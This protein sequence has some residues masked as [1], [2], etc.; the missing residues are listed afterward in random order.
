MSLAPG[1]RLGPYEVLAPLGAGGMGEVYRARDTRLE[2]TVAIKVLPEHLSRSEEVRQ[3]FEREAKTISALS[4]PH[5]CALYD[6]GREGETEYLVM[7]YLEGETLSDRL[8]KGPLPT[9][10]LLRWG[11]EIA[12]ALD[13]AH[14]Q[15]IV[16][17]DL[18]PGNV[19][20]TKSGVKLLDFGLAKTFE[21]SLD[22]TGRGRAAAG[23]DPTAADGITALPTVM[24]SPNLTQAGTILGTFQYMAPEQLEGR[25]ADARSDIFAFGAVLYE[26]ATG[27]KAFEGKSQASLIASILTSDPAPIST[28][29]PLTPPALER[30]VRTCLA[31][32]PEDRWQSAH[33]IA[34]QLSWIAQG[35]SV[36]GVAAP[37]VASRRRQDRLAWVTLGVL[38]GALTAAAVGWALW[39]SRASG[40]GLVTRAVIP[41]P[42][43]ETFV[44]DNYSTLAISPDGRRVAYVARRDNKRQ[45]VQRS[46]DAAEGTSIAGTDG[47]YS[48]FFSPD[49]QWLGFSADG[50]L[51]KVALAGGTPVT[52]CECGSRQLLGAS[53]GADDTIVFP[54]K[55]GGPILRVPSSGGMPSAV[56][57]ISGKGSDRGHIFP[58]LLPGGKAVLFSVFSGGSLDDYTVDVQSLV[59]GERKTLVKGGTFGRYA[60]SGHVLYIRGATLFAVPFDPAR[61]QVTGSAFPVAQG[62]YEN[63]NGGAGYAVSGSGTL[64]YSGGGVQLPGRSLLWVDRQ[65]HATPASGIKRPFNDIKL[66]PDGKRIAL[67][68]QAETYDIWVLDL[69]R[70]SLTRLSFGKDDGSPVWSPDGKRIAF[71]SSQGGSDAVYL[72]SFD[73]SGSEE[74][75]TSGPSDDSRPRTFSPDGRL[76]VFEKTLNGVPEIWAVPLEKGSSARPLLQGPFHH[77][78]GWLSPDGRWL[79]YSSNESGSREIYV[80]AF[81][82]PG[83]KWQISTDGGTSARWSP[84]GRE[85]FY[86]KDKKVMRVAITTSP[87][88]SASRPELLFEG[89]YED[90]DVSRDGKSFLMLKDETAESA[91]KHLNLVLNWFEELKARAPRAAK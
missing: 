38:L 81:P 52:L 75:L 30:V 89:D 80:T 67:Q 78:G 15:G 6:V 7:E 37:V 43:A 63:T 61:L 48:P 9:E 39:R 84:D 17:R 54:E 77:I 55:W 45:L 28:V 19:M 53:W 11:V 18:K 62:V 50:K 46:L 72:R 83:G 22:A 66:S 87:D 91:P 26:M 74:R 41:I 49:G 12:D 51:K 2:R 79:A 35:G 70:D 44:L 3:R 5:I 36:S 24:G 40:A 4:H 34:S 10:Q 82:G 25:E 76:V 31:K 86:A 58:D 16:H 14:R 85:I 42:G 69:T 32:D 65:G 68:I 47:A 1:S 56:T 23:Q 27:R 57:K 59:T 64:L 60:A 29:Q 33:D 21:R 73:G 71:S 88:F 13:K 8:V 90:W 20:L